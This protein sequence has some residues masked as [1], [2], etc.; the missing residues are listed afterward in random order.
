MIMSVEKI[1]RIP[2]SHEFP[3]LPFEFVH[4]NFHKLPFPNLQ[5]QSEVTNYNRYEED[6][7]YSNLLLAELKKL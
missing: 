4:A 7:N 1:E 2:A 5:W 6:I 3:T